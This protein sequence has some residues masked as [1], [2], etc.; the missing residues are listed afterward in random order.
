MWDSINQ[1][2]GFISRTKLFDVIPLD[3]TLHFIIGFLITVVC[4]NKGI[5]PFKVFLILFSIAL[6]K[7]LYD[8]FFHYKTHLKE[9]I[10]DL[11]VTV[12]HFFIYLIMKKLKVK[13]QSGRKGPQM[14]LYD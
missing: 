12:S 4:V 10:G 11:V 13:T 1:V 6:T 9:Y 14:K 5:K 2:L 3:W 8:Y 7:E